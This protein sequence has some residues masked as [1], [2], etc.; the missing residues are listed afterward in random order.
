[1]NNN[2]YDKYKDES[3]DKTIN[4]QNDVEENF[5]KNKI[6]YIIAIVSTIIIFII[7][8]F[9]IFKNKYN[10]SG[11]S[12]YGRDDSKLYKKFFGY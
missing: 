2:S 6:Y 7:I 11:G 9:I 8:I 12:R 10:K 3:I 5:Q 4:R 1:M